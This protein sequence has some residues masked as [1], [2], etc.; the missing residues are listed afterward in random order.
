MNPPNILG[1]PSVQDEDMNLHKKPVE[2]EERS[3][4]CMSTFGENNNNGL[5]FAPTCT[6]CFDENKYLSTSKKKCSHQWNNECLNIP[7]ECI[8]FPSG[9]FHHGYYNDKSNTIFIQ[10]QLFCARTKYTD[11]LQLPQSMMKGQGK[12]VT[13]GHLDKSTLLELRDDLLNNWE[14]QYSNPEYQPCKNFSGT[15]Q[16]TGRLTR[17]ISLKFHYSRT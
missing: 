12:E 17:N 4:S 16:A 14:I 8:L 10:A 5:L 11:I 2:G 3:L 6:T 13:Q 7:G 1:D 9:M 15:E